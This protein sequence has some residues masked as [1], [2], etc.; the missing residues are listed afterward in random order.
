MIR[1]AIVV[2][3]MIILYFTPSTATL[4]FVTV[5]VSFRRDNNTVYRLGVFGDSSMEYYI[6]SIYFRPGEGYKEHTRSADRWRGRRKRFNVGN[7]RVAYRTR[8]YTCKVPPTSVCRTRLVVVITV[9]KNIT[10]VITIY[11]VLKRDVCFC[12]SIY[13]I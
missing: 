11:N 9:I 8:Y 3:T 13:N 10:I 2:I 7:V 1:I 4:V 5:R 6:A 12:F